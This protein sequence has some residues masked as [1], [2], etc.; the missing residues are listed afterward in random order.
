MKKFIMESAYYKQTVGSKDPAY[1]QCYPLTINVL[2]SLTD[3]EHTNTGLD[4]MI[5]TLEEQYPASLMLNYGWFDGLQKKKLEKYEIWGP[6]PCNA[7]CPGRVTTELKVMGEIVCCL[8]SPY[9]RKKQKFN[10]TNNMFIAMPTDAESLYAFLKFQGSADAQREGKL[11]S[12]RLAINK[13]AVPKGFCKGDGFNYKLEFGPM[14]GDFP[15]QRIMHCQGAPTAEEIMEG[16]RVGVLKKVYKFSAQENT[17]GPLGF[18]YTHNL[19]GTATVTIAF[20]PV[21]EERWRVEEERWRVEVKAWE[22]DK[23]KPPIKYKDK[24][25][26]IKELPIWMELDHQLAGE[27]VVRK[28]KNDWTY[29]EGLTTQYKG[30]TRLFFDGTDLYKCAVVDCPGA[31]PNDWGGAI[32]GEMQGRSVKLTWPLGGSSTKACVMCTPLKSFLGKLPYRQEFGSN[33]LKNY[34][35]KEILPLK[36]GFTKNGQVLD[37]L[38]YTITLTKI[39]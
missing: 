3:T 8:D 20:A 6:E 10:L 11:N 21:E 12:S 39:K 15:S 26:Q 31:E 34:L 24:D 23:M 2:W 19:Q 14:G 1:I 35:N 38:K 32:L 22:R 28:V 4:E 27:F 30:W 18:V 36:N 17:S 29:K 37:W 9:C 33:N 25:G 7:P 16:L 5:I 13:N